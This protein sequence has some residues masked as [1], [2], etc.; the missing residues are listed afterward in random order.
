MDEE[1][2]P[3]NEV[4]TREPHESWEMVGSIIGMPEGGLDPYHKNWLVKRCRRSRVKPQILR[5]SCSD[6]LADHDE[7]K[8]TIRDFLRHR[9]MHPIAQKVA[10]IQ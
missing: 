2:C 7:P 9:N 1:V 3:A 6:S 8:Q 5:H 4:T 10:I